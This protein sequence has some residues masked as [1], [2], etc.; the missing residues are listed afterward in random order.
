MKIM[1]IAASA[2]LVMALAG[3]GL[4]AQQ[5]RMNWNARVR[6]ELALDFD[7]ELDINKKPIDRPNID[8]FDK[9]GGRGTGSSWD[10]MG[11]ML[12]WYGINQ[13]SMWGI[14]T[15]RQGWG[16]ETKYNLAYDNARNGNA[17]G[18]FQF[19]SRWDKGIGSGGFDVF[20]I[21]RVSLYGWWQA[22]NKRIYMEVSPFGAVDN[23]WG[24]VWKTP[25]NFFYDR[26]EDAN[27]GLPSE[28]AAYFGDN[29]DAL[30]RMQ[31]R[32]VVD[33][34]NFGFTLPQFGRL[35]KLVWSYN[36]TIVDGQPRYWRGIDILTHA[37]LGF[38]YSF[39]D[40]A[41]AGGFKFDPDKAQRAYLGGEYKI[42]DQRLGIRA[43]FK[44][45]NV[46]GVKDDIADLDMA[47]GLIWNDGFLNVLFSVF[48]RNF[49]WE[50]NKKGEIELQTQGKYVL[51]PRKLLTRLRF[52]YTKGFGEDVLKYSKFEIEPGL[53]WAFGSQSVT[54][55]LGQY[56]GL[57]FRFNFQ[58]GKD[59]VGK[60]I[61][62]KKL[63]VGFRW[64][65]GV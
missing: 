10:T 35:D 38:K 36:A 29:Y 6:T 53:Y 64:T 49:L 28:Q 2:L 48:E 55:D 15:Y 7:E 59:S 11:E 16:F 65:T 31:F 45:L 34:L 61:D 56:I 27:T 42:L 13:I 4:F 51:I 9:D 32:N 62:I 50:D 21:N 1:K 63:I 12:L 19:G 24:D 39:Y 54:D 57:F 33:N 22:W 43:D 37:S 8:F 25:A 40:L 14:V 52:Y 47:Q 3:G 5:G 46:F 58:F 60:D 44:M 41:L 30:F 18:K 20:K 26:D 17:G 23:E